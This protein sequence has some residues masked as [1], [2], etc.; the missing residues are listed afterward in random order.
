MH[1]L[2][3]QEAEAGVPEERRLRRDGD[4]EYARRQP[5]TEAVQGQSALVAQVRGVRRVVRLRVLVRVQR[6]AQARLPQGRPPEG[7][8]PTRAQAPRPQQGQEG[9]ERHPQ[10]RQH[11]HLQHTREMR[12]GMIFISCAIRVLIHLQ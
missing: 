7:A 12:E 1:C 3:G 6:R 11:L 2:A 5:R 8:R 10:R 4:A 9:R